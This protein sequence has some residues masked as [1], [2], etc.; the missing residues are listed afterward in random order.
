MEMMRSR[1]HIKRT[2]KR[3]G[4]VNNH[5]SLEITFFETSSANLSTQDGQARDVSQIA[6]AELSESLLPLAFLQA[7]LL[8]FS[9]T[10]LRRF[11]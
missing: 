9:L 11:G 3:S 4:R 5:Q 7:D 6:S 10:R 8:H 1:W 2:P